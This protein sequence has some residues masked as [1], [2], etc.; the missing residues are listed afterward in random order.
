MASVCTYYIA[1]GQSCKTALDEDDMP[2]MVFVKHSSVFI[3][4]VV[5]GSDFTLPRCFPYLHHMGSGR[6]VD[7]QRPVVRLTCT[8]SF[9]EHIFR[10][11][12]R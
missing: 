1:S 5:G 12:C 11:R 6:L 4:E 3:F 9:V 7:A 2:Y 10:E 8:N